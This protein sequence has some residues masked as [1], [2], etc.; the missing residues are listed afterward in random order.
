MAESIH[1]ARWLN[2]IN[3]QDWDIRLFPSNYSSLHQRQIQNV[4]TYRS[5]IPIKAKKNFFKTF[6]GLKLLCRRGLTF[7]SFLQDKIDPNARARRLCN[8]IEV[9][10]P[11]IIH[12]L[13]FQSGGYLVDQARKIYKG[14]F[15]K[16]IATNWGS[17]IYWYNRFPEHQLKIRSVL[18]NCDFYSCECQR[19][20]CLA[21]INGLKGTKLPVLPNSGGL[22]L[23]KI[24]KWRKSL[25]D[26]KIIMLK[27]KLD[28]WG[29]PLIGLEALEMCV[30]Q[31]AGYQ[32]IIFSG[33][34]PRIKQAA[35][36][37]SRETGVKIKV[38]SEYV[39]HEKILK[40]HGS[41]RIS[42]GLSLSDAISTSFLEAM[43]MGSF[44]IQSNTSCANEWVK[45]KQ[46]GFLV[47]PEK[48]HEIAKAIKK[49]LEN[50]EIVKTA[51]QENW[52]TV[53]KRLGYNSI[54]KKV[55][56]IYKNISKNNVC[57]NGEDQKSFWYKIWL[58]FLKVF[59][60]VWIAFSIFVWV[61]INMDNQIVQIILS[62][63]VP[64]RVRIMAEG[65]LIWFYTDSF[66]S[67]FIYRTSQ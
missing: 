64:M 67:T 30:S 25:K 31:L 46:T 45:N 7:F 35:Y 16:W 27:G 22:D 26:R 40:L 66:A 13:E 51:S 52:E 32:I 21:E 28:M 36:D 50:D 41:A 57:N 53:Q 44:P 3:D 61:M 1:T 18:E 47:S 9:F 19:D 29:K 15:P 65:A 63:K 54:K 12:S 24:K 6:S 4:M 48:P 17:D 37:F 60:C 49:A 42:I 43:A 2:Q 34:D 58:T 56:D 55:I 20:I 33:S 11:D 62:D 39:S 10:R 38:I 59:L 5:C 23:A 14:K 8:I